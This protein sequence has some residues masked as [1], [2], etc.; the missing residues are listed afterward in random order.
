MNKP[1]QIQFIETESRY[2]AKKN[3]PWACIII[4]VEGG[5]KAF[6]LINDYNDWRNQK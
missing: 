4:K 2:K 1:Q 5:Y 6:A 3:A